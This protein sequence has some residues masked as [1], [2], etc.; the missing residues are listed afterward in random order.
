MARGLSHLPV[1]PGKE[2]EFLNRELTPYVRDLGTQVGALRVALDGKPD[3]D[4]LPQLP[5]P[6][7]R[8]LLDKLSVPAVS[9][10]SV[11]RQLLSTYYGPAI[12]VRR[13]DN[14]EQDIAFINGLLDLAA[15]MQFVGS[16]SGF[17]RWLYDQC[18]GRRDLGNATA[19]EQPRIVNAGVLETMGPSSQPAAFFDGSN[20]RL[21]GVGPGLTGSP[22]LTVGSAAQWLSANAVWSFGSS[23]SFSSRISLFRSGTGM[24]VL[25]KEHNNSNKAFTPLA[26]PASAPMSYV[27]QH[28][29]GA[30]VN[31]GTLRQNGVALSS[32]SSAGTAALTLTNDI[33]VLGNVTSSGFAGQ[34]RQNMFIVLN[35]LLTGDNL[36]L[37]EQELTAHLT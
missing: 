3:F 12:R 15:L 10:F 21:T 14:A 8:Y 26:D 25:F 24:S 32:P 20:D 13:D 35:A 19:A 31:T 33:T 5:Q 27:M 29:A 23:S 30:T 11:A 7:P 17:L 37:L 16:G 18:P 2:A 6:S 4:D 28:A 34:S 22:N 1:A 36:G 9:A